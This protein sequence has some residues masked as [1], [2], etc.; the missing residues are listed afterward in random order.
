MYAAG[1]ALSRR[2]NVDLFIDRSWFPQQEQRVFELDCFR[3]GGILIDDP[4]T[5]PLLARLH[6]RRAYQMFRHKVLRRPVNYYYEKTFSFDP[7]VLDLEPGVF[8]D[9][10]LQSFRYFDEYSTDLRSRI[11]QLNTPSHWYLQMRDSLLERAP[12]IGVHV[13]RGDYEESDKRSVHGLVDRTFYARAFDYLA[14][15][16]PDSQFIVFSDDPAAA[17]TLLAGLPGDREYFVSPKDTVALETILL[18]S[19]AS[20]LITANSS[21]SWWSAWIGDAPD[22]PVVTPRPWFNSPGVI[23]DDLL[24]MNW[25]SLG[26]NKASG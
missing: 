23:L 18:M 12:W 4:K 16:L 19:L 22:R 25:L 13:R 20:G 14:R 15:L 3:H 11:R 2:L 24:P 17:Q 9:G 1:Y 10:Y 6:R 8:L 26:R 5:N 21:F 7:T